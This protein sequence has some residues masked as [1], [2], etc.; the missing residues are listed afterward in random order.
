MPISDFL[1][2]NALTKC[3]RARSIA[4]ALLLPLGLVSG[5]AALAQSGPPIPWDKTLTVT[6]TSSEEDIKTVLRSLL[7]ANGLSVIFT[8]DVEGTISF[9]LEKVPVA[10]AFDQV[11]QQHNLAYTYNPN[12]KTVSITTLAAD[13]ERAKSGAFVPL[14]QVTYDEL[15]RAL[16]NFGL[17]AQSLKYDPGTR[18]VAIN[19]DT[20]HVQQIADLIK[21]LESAHQKQRDRL[22]QERTRD[23]QLK[24]AELTQQ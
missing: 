10:S 7:Q 22:N 1:T 8:P 21:T 23:L 5:G 15:T 18:T 24:R 3:M 12:A 20:E 14:D 9:R 2:T 19:G 4:T 17:S 16:E 11:V 13:A 6:R